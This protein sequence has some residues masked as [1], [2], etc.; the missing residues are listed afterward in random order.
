VLPACGTVEKVFTP[1]KTLLPRESF[2]ISSISGKSP[3]KWGWRSLAQMS[4]S[5]LNLAAIQRGTGIAPGEACPRWYAVYTVSNH[6]KSVSAHFQS[7]Q[8]VS[9]LPL[10]RTLRRWNNGCKVEVDLPLFPNYVFVQID[11]RDR[12]RV[13]SVP[14]VIAIV[15]SSREG[16]PVPD[17]EIDMI[18]LGLDLRKIEPH[19]YLTVGERVRIKAGALEGLEGVLI[20]K[21]N[22]LRVVIT[23]DLIM[24]SVAIEVDGDELEPARPRVARLCS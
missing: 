7:R 23:L 19:P 3:P 24:K 6:E 1:K 22:D 8:I 9:Y 10:W 21:K 20:R 18:R 11:R 15:G 17:S 12:G 14:G 2:V 13:L 5:L 4:N 16:T